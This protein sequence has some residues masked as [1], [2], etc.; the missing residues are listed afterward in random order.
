MRRK[1]LTSNHFSIICRTFQGIGAAGAYSMSILTVYDMVPK[2][3]LALYGAL[4]SITIAVATLTG[5]IF[6]GL[7]DKGSNWRWIFY[8]KLVFNQIKL[9]FS[10]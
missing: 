4:I 2:E 6:G 7:L 8:L 9:C 3:K 5:P 1:C 10:H